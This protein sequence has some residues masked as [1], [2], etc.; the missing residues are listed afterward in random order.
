[1][2]DRQ[3]IMVERETLDLIDQEVRRRRMADGG[4]HSRASVV[5]DAVRGLV[6]RRDDPSQADMSHR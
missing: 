2:R 4:R 6:R 3:A 1:M 5:R